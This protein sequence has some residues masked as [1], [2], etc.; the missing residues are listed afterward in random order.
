MQ[1]TGSPLG[2]RWLYVGLAVAGLILLTR[3]VA[4][5]RHRRDLLSLRGAAFVAACLLAAGWTVATV[6]QDV[7][8]PT[9]KTRTA[10]TACWAHPVGGATSPSTGAAGAARATRNTWPGRSGRQRRRWWSRQ[11]TMTRRRRRRTLAWR[12]N[13]RRCPNRRADQTTAA[14]GSPRAGRPTGPVWS[15]RGRASAGRRALVCVAPGRRPLAAQTAS[16]PAGDGVGFL[17]MRSRDCR[18]GRRA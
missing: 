1:A 13:P 5:A 14:P 3:V 8:V 15:V 11:S 4:M 12:V 18:I 7:R 16:I 10:R 6:A 9:R 17:P 2:I